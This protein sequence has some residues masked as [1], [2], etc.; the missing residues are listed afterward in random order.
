[1]GLW[2]G[3]QYHWKRACTSRFVGCSNQEYC[4]QSR[5]PPE[6]WGG[7]WDTIHRVWIPR[8][9]HHGTF[10]SMQLPQLEG[11]NHTSLEVCFSL[12]LSGWNVCATRQ[13][14]KPTFLM[15]K[16]SPRHALKP[17]NHAACCEGA[18]T[19]LGSHLV[20]SVG[21]AGTCT[22]GYSREVQFGEATG[23]ATSEVWG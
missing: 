13:S 9:L 10:P 12:A 19:T 3:S 17:R 8:Q 14:P 23:S 18:G 4:P 2:Q 5:N 11:L 15:V 21:K 1:M 6:A 16:P 22:R 20:C 7:H